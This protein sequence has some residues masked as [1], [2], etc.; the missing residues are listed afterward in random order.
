MIQNQAQLVRLLNCGM[1]II[2]HKKT[3]RL[4]LQTERGNEM[5]TVYIQHGTGTSGPFSTEGVPVIDK[6]MAHHRRGLS[7]TATGYGKRIPTPYMIK[8]R[9]KLRRVYCMI[10]SNSGTLY[11]GKLSDNLI[12]NIQGE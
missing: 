1:I 4:N 11:I 6:P 7:F 2:M 9:G 12:V 10:Y 5:K 3:I 8:Y